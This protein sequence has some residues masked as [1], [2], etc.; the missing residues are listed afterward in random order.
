M[1][2]INFCQLLCELFQLSILQYGINPSQC[3]VCFEMKAKSIYSCLFF[4]SLFPIAPEI[5][6]YYNFSSHNPSAVT[7]EA[8]MNAS[9]DPCSDFDQYVCGKFYAK[10]LERGQSAVFF[11]SDIHKENLKTLQG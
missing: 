3:F 8:L 2:V 9:A 5:S 11:D 6:K 10:K 1:L 7:I 4:P